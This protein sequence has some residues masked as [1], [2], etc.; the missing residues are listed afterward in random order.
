ML[1]RLYYFILLSSFWIADASNVNAQVNSKATIGNV[2]R[3]GQNVE[4]TINAPEPF[5]VGGNVFV[6]HI[7]QF[8]TDRYRQTDVDGKG[9]LTF[10]IPDSQYSQLKEGLSIYLSYGVF[11]AEEATDDEALDA[12]KGSPDKA[13]YLGKLTAQM[14]HK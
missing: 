9:T 12:C 7:G 3:I 1:N 10:I 14:L 8:Y 13:K 2:V 4:F 11:W 6:L 5:Y